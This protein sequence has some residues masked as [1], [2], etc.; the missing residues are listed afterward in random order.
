MC[1][2][3][4]WYELSSN[5]LIRQLFVKFSA[6]LTSLLHNPLYLPLW[7]RRGGHNPQPYVGKAASYLSE[8][9][10]IVSLVF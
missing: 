1:K 10:L 5:L 8:P 2:K 4:I 3:T 7:K 6:G 9:L